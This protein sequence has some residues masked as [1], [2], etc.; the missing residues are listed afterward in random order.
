M[1]TS[2]VKLSHVPDEWRRRGA[3][4]TTWPARRN[5]SATVNDQGRSTRFATAGANATGIVLRSYQATANVAGA[6]VPALN[7]VGRFH[8]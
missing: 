3:H 7:L 4:P 5:A 6:A 8:F 2:H 1:D